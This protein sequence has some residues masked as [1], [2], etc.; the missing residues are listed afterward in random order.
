ME[1]P[2][3]RYRD[4]EEKVKES[5]KPKIE[6]VVTGEVIRQK[7]SIGRR[8]SEKFVAGDARTVVSYIFLDVLIPA[9]KDAIADSFSMGVEKMLFGEARS[10]S[11]RGPRPGGPGGYVSYNR[12][13]AAGSARSLGRRD[14]R[15][16]DRPRARQGHFDDIILA[17]RVEAEEVLDRLFDLVSRYEEATV[18]DLYDLVNISGSY[19]DEKWG[20]R[21]LR[22]ARVDRVRNGYLLDLPKPEP[23]D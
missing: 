9:A 12:Y 18:A 7:K 16:D 17:T 22:G 10:V 8:F 13:A 5:E 1:Y 6:P 19:T 11:R 4:K 2:S 20:W 21:D 15:R 14:E 23:L 3:N